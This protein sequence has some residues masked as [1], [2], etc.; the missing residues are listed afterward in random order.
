MSTFRVDFVTADFSPP[1]VVIRM[2]DFV[3]ISFSFHRIV[4]QPDMALTDM[5]STRFASS[6]HGG[7]A[8]GRAAAIDET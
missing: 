7:V 4:L 8:Q 5:S 2:S 1:I 3:F 6:P